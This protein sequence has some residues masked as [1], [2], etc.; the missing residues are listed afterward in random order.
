[1]FA[2]TIALCK[3]TRD[4]C[5]PPSSLLPL[6]KLVST[7][8]SQ[9]TGQSNN[10]KEGPL[11]CGSPHWTLTMQKRAHCGAG[12]LTGLL[13]LGPKPLARVDAHAPT[14]GAS[15][16]RKLRASS[17][18]TKRASSSW[19][20]GDAKQLV[21]L[22]NAASITSLS[23][24]LSTRPRPPLRFGGRF[25]SSQCTSHQVACIFPRSLRHPPCLLLGTADI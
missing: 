12:L 23:P 11:W 3:R 10:A 7:S 17:P 5:E 4:V 21:T 25:G 14:Q 13:D 18:W 8:P 22:P 20:I 6:A 9:A 24:H 15:S 16:Q 19:T 2:L 1:V